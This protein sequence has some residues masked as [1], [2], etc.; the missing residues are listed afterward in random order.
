[1][2]RNACSDLGLDLWKIDAEFLPLKPEEIEKFVSMW[3]R[4]AILLNSGLYISASEIEDKQMKTII[5]S[6]VMSINS[7]LPIFVGTRERWSLTDSMISFEVKK[8]S[9]EEQRAL[10]K[11]YFEKIRERNGL[12]F[13]DADLIEI[14]DKFELNA[15]EIKTCFEEAMVTLET[16]ESNTSFLT[17]VHKACG[18]VTRY[19]MGN[20]AVPLRTTAL[21]KDLVLPDLQ[22]KLINAIGMHVKQRKKV[23]DEF[24]FRTRTNRGLGITAL[25]IG[26]SGT[27]KTMAAEALANELNLDLLKIDLAMVVSKWV[28]ETEQHLRTLFDAAE[29]GG[30]ILFFDEADTLFAKRTEVKDSHDT[31]M[32]REIGYLLQKTEEYNGLAILASNMKT[33]IDPAFIRRINFIVKFPFPDQVSRFEIWKKIFPA[34]TP[35]GDIDL[36]SLSVLNITGG[37]IRNIAL[38]AAFIAAEGKVSVS[39]SQIRQAVKMEYDKLERSLTNQELKAIGNE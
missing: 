22:K 18:M 1:L 21:L 26:E 19:K 11:V 24:G 13:A 30:S 28:G 10:W 9:K 36:K 31:H 32:N 38:N 8:L 25:F 12:V 20:F 16:R 37:N 7:S 34:S 33:S 3:S 29:S 4:E 2:A 35:L 39:M 27:G 6:L 5:G 14:T 17:A 15:Y 23:Y